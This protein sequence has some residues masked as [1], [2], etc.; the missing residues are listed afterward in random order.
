MNV[1]CTSVINKGQVVSHVISQQ[2]S[3]RSETRARAM[4]STGVSG[5]DGVSAE[6]T[7]DSTMGGYVSVRGQPSEVKPLLRQGSGEGSPK[8][9]LRKASSGD[10]RKQVKRQVSFQDDDV[11][12]HESG[13]ECNLISSLW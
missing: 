12:Y 4:Q 1:K 5:E 9:S 11:F 10:F 2:G 8:S 13:G 7:A 3:A 6:R